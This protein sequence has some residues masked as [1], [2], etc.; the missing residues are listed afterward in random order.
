[1]TLLFYPDLWTLYG[2]GAFYCSGHVKPL[3]NDGGGGGD[4]WQICHLF[5]FL[6]LLSH[7]YFFA[8]LLFAFYSLPDLTAED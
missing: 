5:V 2:H 1:M 8:R 3:C 6:Q 4:N 7:F